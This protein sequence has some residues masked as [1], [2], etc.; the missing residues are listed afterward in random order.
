MWVCVCVQAWWMWCSNES[1]VHW[2]ALSSVSYSFAVA[3][4]FLCYRKKPWACKSL[5]QRSQ[6][7]DLTVLENV[8][9]ASYNVIYY[10]SCYMCCVWYNS[11]AVVSVFG[12][13]TG[14]KISMNWLQLVSSQVVWHTTI[15]SAI[16]VRSHLHSSLITLCK[17]T[18]AAQI[19]R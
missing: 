14:Q 7:M 4:I 3:W 12:E 6:N 17:V 15:R 11:L 13:R 8:S 2:S 19:D 9:A 1:N 10:F 16:S 18:Y 5:Q